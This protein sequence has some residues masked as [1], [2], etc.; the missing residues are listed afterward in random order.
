MRKILNAT[1]NTLCL[2]LLI[3]APALVTT[4]GC[5]LFWGEPKMPESL[6]ES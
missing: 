3:A 2:A 1:A 4:R 6:K 5:V